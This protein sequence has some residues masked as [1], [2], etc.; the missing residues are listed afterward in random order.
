MRADNFE[1]PKWPVLFTGG[2]LVR[3]GP[4]EGLGSA[5]FGGP[6]DQEFDG[7]SFGPAPLHRI[8]TVCPRGMPQSEGHNLSGQVPL[9]HGMQFEGCDLCYQLP[10]S[11]HENGQIVQA[12]ANPTIKRMSPIESKATWPYANYPPVLPYVPLREESRTTIK[13]KEFAERYT[14]QGLGDFFGDELVVVVPV[15]PSLGVS[16]WGREGDLED[17]QL[18]FRYHYST[19]EVRAYSQYGG[20]GLFQ[21]GA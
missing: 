2:V 13:P 11:H 14:W 12:R 19:N 5:Y 17:V 7:Q 3:Y 20:P 8:L 21:S 4:S 9:F 10:V 6:L 15:I 1:M 18:V 16:L